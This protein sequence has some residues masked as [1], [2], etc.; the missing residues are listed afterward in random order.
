M[1]HK[2]IQHGFMFNE[3]EYDL[4]TLNSYAHRTWAASPKIPDE[5]PCSDPS[6]DRVLIIERIS[7]IFP[8]FPNIKTYRIRVDTTSLLSCDKF[9]IETGEYRLLRIA[10]ILPCS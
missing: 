2:G 3:Y 10:T 8:K 6:I 4:S 9:N 7:A 1:L 5:F